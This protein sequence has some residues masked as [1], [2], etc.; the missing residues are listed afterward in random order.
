MPIKTGRRALGKEEALGGSN[1]SFRGRV[2][3][4]NSSKV[5]DIQAKK[6]TC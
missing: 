1:Q 5:T 4:G 2:A 3:N 6:I